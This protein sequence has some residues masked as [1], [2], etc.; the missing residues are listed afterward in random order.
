MAPHLLAFA[1]HTPPEHRMV[2]HRIAGFHAAAL[3]IILGMSAGDW[4]AAAPACK[5]SPRHDAS[6]A[7]HGAPHGSPASDV[8][9][10]GDAATVSGAAKACRCPRRPP[11]TTSAVRLAARSALAA[12][13]L[14]SAPGPH[15][16][17]A[18][19]R[20]AALHC[21]LSSHK[22]IRWLVQSAQRRVPTSQVSSSLTNV[23]MA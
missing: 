23:A 17:A 4:H 21:R 18:H 2:L 1:Q 16:H 9:C 3:R 8:A 19:P 10:P 15:R 14:S 13:H 12:V 22:P 5:A 7:L 11:L 20:H 6:R